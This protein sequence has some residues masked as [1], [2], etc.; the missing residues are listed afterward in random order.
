MK[1]LIG[2]AVFLVVGVVSYFYWPSGV[3]VTRIVDGDN[4][5]LA[6][7]REIRYINVDT[8]EEGECY[9]EESTKMNEELVMG[10]KV[11]VEYDYDRVGPN[12]REL[13][14]VYLGDKM[15]NEELLKIGA[16][17]FQR[18]NNNHK[19]EEQLIE[20]AETSRKEKKGLWSACAVDGECLI[21]GNLDRNDNRYYHLPGFRHY[22]QVVMRLDLGDRW[23][24]SE[25]A[26]IAAEFVRARE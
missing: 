25:Q 20:I 1:K 7:E 3:E 21:K 13:A 2:L 23:F 6:D 9:R 16:G 17:E 5:V 14:Y 12:T 19:Y 22:D 26:A 24:C 10:K 18:D 4:I 8:P 15:V 11:R